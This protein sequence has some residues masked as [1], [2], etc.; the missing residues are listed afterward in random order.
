[1]LSY[2]RSRPGRRFRLTAFTLIELL[3]V[4]AIIAIL[5]G[6]LLPAVQKV[7]EAAARAKCQN[8]L[9]QIGLA[10]HNYHDVNSFLPPGAAIDR[11]P[12]AGPG[13]VFG[14]DGS[15]WLVFILPYVEQGPLFSRMTFLG[16]SGWNNPSDQGNPQ[17]SSNVNTA[18]AANLT[19]SVYRCPSDPKAALVNAR[20]RHNLANDVMITRSSYMGVAGAV[21][22]IDNSGAFK[23]SRTSAG[24]SACG[25][26]SAGGM[27]S[28]RFQRVTL[29]AVT[30]G[31]SNTAM[32]TEDA[33]ILFDDFGGAN[34][35]R[36][37]ED[38]GAT[39]CGF[40]SGGA[41]Q[42]NAGTPDGDARGFNV[43]TTRWRINQKKGWSNTVV[44]RTS[45]A[46]AQGICSS[47]SDPAQFSGGADDPGMNTPWNSAHTGGVNV[48]AGDGSVRFLR[49]STD[50]VT[51]ARYS[52]RDDGQVFTLD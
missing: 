23:E 10:L 30:D 48:L 28:P 22:N 24:W 29:Q 1:M 52:T 9:K 36:R 31:T 40:L 51:L 32:V 7:R 46:T 44:S 34:P 11:P 21:D 12:Y 45:Q 16:N 49:D 26:A 50:L 42:Q 6:L 41:F 25:I 47:L 2:A 43:S 4:I 14:G 13:N 17:S 5:I 39:Q 15:S 8:N 3:V 19:L 18:A 20:V 27:L 37:R 33:D 38:W 35:G